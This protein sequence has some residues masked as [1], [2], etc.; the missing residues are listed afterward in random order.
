MMYSDQK[1]G[2]TVEVE[3]ARAERE[4]LVLSDDDIRTLGRWAMM[5]EDHYGRP[6]DV[7]WA[8]D[9]ESGEL[10]IVQA[11]PETVQSQ[12]RSGSMTSVRL[13]ETSE[14]LLS[15]LSIGESIA[16]G[17]VKLVHD[18]SELTP[19]PKATFWSRK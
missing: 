19:C 7:E 2:E 8:K 12:K 9:G 4:Q 14:R 10:F 1:E 3:T 16:S 18:A 5:I 15:G 11:R 17:P 13:T 6:M